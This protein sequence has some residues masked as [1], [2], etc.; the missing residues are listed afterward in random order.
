M[1]GDEDD[2]GGRPPGRG[3]PTD[4]Q[5]A[6]PATG[7]TDG[8][9][10]AERA[11][12]PAD[13]PSD[14][15][16]RIRR[17]LREV[18]REGQKAAAIYA[19]VD[20][21]LVALAVNLA[22]RFLNPSFLPETVPLP[23]V[24][25]ERLGL[26]VGAVDTAIVAG[27]VLG[28]LAF[29]AELAVRIRRPLVE[30]FEAANPEVR[31]ALRT[32]RDAVDDG[33]DSQMA[34][35]LYEDVIARLGRA[36]SVGLLDLRRLTAT[37]AVL[38]LISVASI[39]VA[40]VGLDLD[41]LTAAGPGADGGGPDQGRPDDPGLEEGDDILGEAE[42]VSAGDKPLEAE[43]PTQ[44]SGDDSGTSPPSSYDTGYSGAGDV[45][46]QDAG[47][48]ADEQLAD[49]ELIRQYN[50]KIRETSDETESNS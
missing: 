37:V 40:V 17:A 32:A 14:T 12:D 29:T 47:Y 8:D 1:S 15:S 20:A 23:G 49:A 13:G 46:G 3:D 44:G 34:R 30:Q 25:V 24:V 50:L 6:D 16:R 9:A 36:S 7:S 41:D 26:A 18:R 10:V 43:L 5:A 21:A 2:A 45:E 48:V 4:G 39:Q 27:V 19:V 31:E 35:A 11:A 28:L 33:R 22:I 42:N 38:L